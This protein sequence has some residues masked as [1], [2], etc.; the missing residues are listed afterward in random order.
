[1]S[2]TVP[3]VA[4]KPDTKDYSRIKAVI[5]KYQ[6]ML[7]EEH[8]YIVVRALRAARYVVN[9]RYEGGSEAQK[10]G[11]HHSYYFDMRR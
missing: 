7:A 1:M 9:S 3:S 10:R 4:Y 6:K 2:R 11:I 5:A 8:G